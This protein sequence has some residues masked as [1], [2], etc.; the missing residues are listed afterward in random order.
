MKKVFLMDLYLH[1][2][3]N[4]TT[5]TTASTGNDLSPEMKT[6]YDTMLIREAE[7]ELVHNQFGQKKPIPKGKGKVI[8]F[9]KYSSLGKALTPIS[10]GVTPSG[11][12]LNVSSINATVSQYGGY[13]EIS[14]MLI[15]TAIDNNLQEA[16]RLIATQAGKTLDTVTREVLNAGT[17]VL[18]AGGV[19]GRG[20]LVGGDSTAANN[21]YLTVLDVKKA[22][23]N[24]EVANAKRINGYFVGIIHPDAAFDL[25]NDPDWKY[26]H[27]YKDTT[28]L[29]AGEIGEV[30]GV[31][32]VKTT[33]A[34]VF[35]AENLLGSTRT[36][37]VAADVSENA[38]SFTYTGA[39][40]NTVA[41]RE[42]MFRGKLYKASTDSAAG[43]THTVAI[44]TTATGYEHALPAIDV[45]DDTDIIVYPGEA[46]KNGR[47][48]YS[49]LII[50]QDAY[51]V[52]EVEGG[53]LEH[54]VK[55]L[56]SAGTA[57]PL[58]QRATCGWKATAVAER[59]VEQYMVRIESASTYQVGAN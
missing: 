13:V 24:L 47:D 14:D 34:K 59:L 56:G 19:S 17:N 43:T 22:V 8:E 30:A 28:A 49:T 57:D 23:R 29:Y 2:N 26:P 40:T 10:E 52:T 6:Y 4:K 51:G 42:L 27:Q 35:H 37:T 21:K 16:T 48:V 53:G 9:R 39:A 18:Y 11:Q 36:L 31:R 41:G 20:A 45:S 38:T 3:T 46:G 50:G 12:K 58:D 1:D 25:T 5:D 15:L 55:Q 7:A 54:I 44:D 33:E 32:F